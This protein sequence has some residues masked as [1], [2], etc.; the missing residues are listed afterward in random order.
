MRWNKTVEKYASFNFGFGK[1]LLKIH[2]YVL[3]LLV[4]FLKRANSGRDFPQ[5][6]TK[7]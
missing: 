1:I 3:F 7:E 4:L 5:Y 2:A 6:P